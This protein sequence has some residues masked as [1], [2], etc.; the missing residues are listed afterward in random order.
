MI[1]PT[2]IEKQHKDVYAHFGAVAGRVAALEMVLTQMV[3]LNAKRNGKVTTDEDFENMEAAL[4]NSQTLGRL[5]KTVNAQVALP[6]LT[7]QVMGEALMRRNFLMHHFFRERAFEFETEAGRKRLVK[8]LMEAHAYVLVATK[9]ASDLC[10]NMAADF[11]ITIE[12]IET[13]AE[14]LREAARKSEQLRSNSG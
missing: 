12:D 13:E 10:L 2:R 11:G 6:D 4:Q 5:I 1:S 3:L 8:E 14:R 7:E 9:L